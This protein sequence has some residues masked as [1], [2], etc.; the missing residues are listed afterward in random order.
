MA[1]GLSTRDLAGKFAFR[2]SGFSMRNN[3]LY[4]L[5]G[6]GTFTIDED[7]NLLGNHRSSLTPLQGQDATLSAGNYALDGEISLNE[8]GVTGYAKIFFKDQTKKGLDLNGEFYVVAAGSADRLWLV[9]SVDTIPPENPS[10]PG[11]AADELVSLEAVRF[12]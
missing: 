8:D 2:F 11:I 4:N 7:G 10:G 1:D 3:V 9:S 5:A 12:A 6:V